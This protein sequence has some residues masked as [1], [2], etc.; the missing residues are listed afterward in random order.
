MAERD[1]RWA[2]WGLSRP[3]GDGGPEG[4]RRGL[5]CPGT[6]TIIEGPRKPHPRR[7]K[8]NVVSDS[9]CLFCRIASG[10]IPADEVYSDENVVAFR[11]IAPQAPTHILIIPRKHIASVN[12]LEPQDTELMG[13]LYQV[14]KDLASQEGVSEDGYRMVINAGADG[15][16]TVFHI[17]LHLLGGRPMTWPPG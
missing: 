13:R 17:H 10:E 6:P 12:D 4:P 11:D 5:R 8:G 1:G 14:A 7:R 9:N 2:Q 3:H 15:G 16:Q